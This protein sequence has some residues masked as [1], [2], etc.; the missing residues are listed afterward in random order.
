MIILGLDPGT[1]I[2]GW[3]V[4][5]TGERHDVSKAV[6]LAYDCILTDKSMTHSQRLVAIANGLEGL[7]RQYTPDLVSIEKLFFSTNKTTAM[8]V[9]QARGVLLYVIEKEG[10]PIM[11]FNPME[12]KLALTGYGKADK[13]QMQQMI[14]LILKLDAIPKPDDAADA[15]AIALTAAQTKTY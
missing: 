3:G 13:K 1:A 2:V 12:I 15:L 6:C 5:D 14:K 9:S 11:E 4:I 7:L 10:L 8:S